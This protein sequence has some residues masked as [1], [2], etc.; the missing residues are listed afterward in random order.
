MT[1]AYEILSH[2]VPVQCEN[3]LMTAFHISG[4]V[5][6]ETARELFLVF[7]ASD[8]AESIAL[9]EG[10]WHLCINAEKAGTEAL[11][12]AS[13]AIEIPAICAMVFVKE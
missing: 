1:S 5:P 10:S 11:A 8:T 13:G 2:V 3:S 4:D 9:P 12:V 7:N 6:G